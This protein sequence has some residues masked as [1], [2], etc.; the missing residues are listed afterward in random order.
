MKIAFIAYDRP[1]YH[2]G[3]I[4]NARRLLP[5]LQCRGHDVHALIIFQNGSAPT[6]RYL[7][8][9]GVTVHTQAWL[10][11]TEQQIDW[12]LK[13][14]MEVKPDIFVPNLSVAGYFAA[15]WARDAG[16]ATIAAHRSDDAYHWN[17]ID[18]FVCGNEEWAVSGLV[19][20]SQFL[21]SQVRKRHPRF[22]KLCVIPSGVPLPD[23][24]AEHCEGPL[25]IAYVGRLVQQQKRVFDL[26]DALSGV[27][28]KIPESTATLFGSAADPSV[29]HKINEK[30]LHLGLE[31]HIDCAGSISPE[32]LHRELLSFHVL[33]LLSDYE[34]TPGAVMDGMS[35]GLV[36]VCLNIPGGVQE[37]V[38]H[39]K[40]GLLVDNREDR[41]V[42]A[43]SRLNK[44]I[45]LRERLAKNARAHIENHFSLS[46]AADR[47]ECFFDD[48]VDE[49][50]SAPKDINFPKRFNLPPVRQGLA[51]EDRRQP[52]GLIRFIKQLKSRMN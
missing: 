39:E 26:I 33:V 30:I 7:Q 35:C 4:V 11:Y 47:W 20:V 52:S 44:D 21:S 16:I 10:Q 24:I 45:P 12:I 28:Q 6:A 46:N 5:E 3:P 42:D 32:K 29:Q 50:S 2:N 43:I 36:P 27:I 19:C 18:E 49:N 14:L 34:G 15:R 31:N 48:L 1:G 25:R 17:M 9:Q 41:F 51:R 22:T 40:T 38:L 13:V 37:L 8:E 23:T